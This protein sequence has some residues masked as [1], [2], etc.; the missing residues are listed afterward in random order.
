MWWKGLSF[1]LRMGSDALELRVMEA[2]ITINITSSLHPD[3]G[4]ANSCLRFRDC[5]H[6]R[7]S[8]ASSHSVEQR[9]DEGS[10]FQWV[11]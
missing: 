6:V 2:T 8:D 10:H 7:P 9:V 1:S 11:H 5:V 3:A 4:S